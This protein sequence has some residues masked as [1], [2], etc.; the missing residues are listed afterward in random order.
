MGPDII[1]VVKL[2]QI[3]LVDGVQPAEGARLIFLVLRH[4]SKPIFTCLFR[5]TLQTWQ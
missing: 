2:A 3:Q 5:K 1:A 4:F